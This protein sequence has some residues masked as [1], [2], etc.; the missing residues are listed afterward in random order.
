MLRPLLPPPARVSHVYNRWLS[1]E[2]TQH[3]R[4]MCRRARQPEV[5]QWPAPR[6]HQNHRHVEL[7]RLE[8]YSCLSIMLFAIERFYCRFGESSSRKDEAHFLPSI[9]MKNNTLKSS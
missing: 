5:A 4:G 1:R 6:V 7:I 3:A 8:L 9:S 2:D